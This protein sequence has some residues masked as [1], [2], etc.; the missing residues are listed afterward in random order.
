MLFLAVLLLRCG[1][2]SELCMVSQA[3]EGA[4]NMALCS[5]CGEKPIAHTETANK[6]Q[7]ENKTQP[8]PQTILWQPQNRSNHIKRENKTN[9]FHL[10]II[11][12]GGKKSRLGTL[13]FLIE[14][15]RCRQQII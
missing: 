13:T 3:Q 10:L 12:E 14:P 15:K 7:T 11:K 9:L 2:K 8:R 1:I 4:F 5:S 6:K